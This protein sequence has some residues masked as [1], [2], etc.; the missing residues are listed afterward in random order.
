MSSIASTDTLDDRR[1]Q[2]SLSSAVRLSAAHDE[3]DSD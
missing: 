2:P 1:D 3:A